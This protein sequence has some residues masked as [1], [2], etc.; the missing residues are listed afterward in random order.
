MNKTAD[1]IRETLKGKSLARILFNWAV[2]ETCVNLGGV[3]VDLASGDSHSYAR[4]WQINSAKMI[5]VDID[6][7]SRP[8]IVADLNSSLP[9]ESDL[10]D[11]IFL[12]N[13]FYLI[14][15]SGNLLREASR[16]LKKGGRFFLTAEFI[17][18]EETSVTDYQRFT[19]RRLKG[20][21]LK[22]GFR[23]VKIEPIGER[24]CA[25]VNLGDFV[26]N[27]PILNIF[28]IPGRVIALALDS[29][30]PRRLRKNYPCPICWFVIAKK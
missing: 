22:E 6:K 29:V 15:E 19:S 4:Y 26:F 9:L 10:A 30:A 5:K 20:L 28:K 16:I 25:I 11:N 24:F 18:S 13:S 1:L 12:F 8:D 17:K 27:Y 3:C 14:E 23:E 7:E 21:F 2:A